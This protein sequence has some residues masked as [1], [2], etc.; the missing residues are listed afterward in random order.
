M[1]RPLSVWRSGSVAT[2]LIVL[3]H[4][5]KSSKRSGTRCELVNFQPEL[6]QHCYVQIRQRVVVFGVKGQMLAVFETAARENDWQIAIVV[7][8]A[9]HVR[10]EHHHCAVEQVGV[11]LFGFF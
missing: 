8:T 11:T 1:T 9:M 10:T 7:T 2:Q 4:S 3:R 5:L 6:L